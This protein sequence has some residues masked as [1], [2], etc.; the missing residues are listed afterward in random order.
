MTV[1]AG[2][3]TAARRR[4]DAVASAM[5]IFAERGLTTGAIQQVADDIGV[6]QPYVFRLFGS[7][8]ALFLACLDELESRLRST[9]RDA[10]AAH[11]ADPLP[12][13]RASFRT[14]IADGVVTGLWLQACAAARTD[15][16][17]A[18]RCRALIGTTLDEAGRLAGATSD[19]LDSALATGALVVMLQALDVD[20]TRGSRAAVDS[21]RAPPAAAGGEPPV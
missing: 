2:R 9:F 1:P 6:T 20:L 14:L 18:A 7:K 13:V 4:A 17:V 16:A 12:A 5:R 15:Q 19:E 11:P 3:S 10:A 8:Q 21:L